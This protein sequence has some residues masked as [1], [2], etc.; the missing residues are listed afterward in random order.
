MLKF[1]IKDFENLE[2]VILKF[3]I[4]NFENLEENNPQ[5]NTCIIHNFEQGS[6]D[7]FIKRLGKITASNIFNFRGNSKA[8]TKLIYEKASEIING[9][10]PEQITSKDIDRGK[11]LEPVAREMYQFVTNSKVNEIGFAELNEYVGVSPDGLVADDGLIEIKCPRPTGFLY[12]LIN[13][14]KSIDKLYI[15][16]MQM[17]MY[18]CN[19][20]WCDYVI[21]NENFANSIH[22]IRIERDE[23]IIEEIKEVIERAVSEI[24]EIITIY[25][26]RGQ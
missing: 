21:Y 13:G 17:Q 18:V 6:D 10:V 14:Y 12:Q 2:E 1:D 7:W 4:K 24:K 25:K 15:Y 22:I 8:R 3:D 26:Q 20:Q 5:S 23:D 19:R 16:Q 9:I 11:E